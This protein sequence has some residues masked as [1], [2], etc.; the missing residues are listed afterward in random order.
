MLP[1]AAGLGRGYS[2]RM[3]R[4]LLLVSALV[5]AAAWAAVAGTLTIVRWPPTAAAI[6]EVRDAGMRGCAGRYS[7]PAA[8]GR[9]EVLF[10]T[11]YVMERNIAVFTRALVALGPL[12]AVGVWAAVGRR[13]QTR[14]RSA[15][16]GAARP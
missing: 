15:G 10:E 11:Q 6:V 2:R 13:R 8:R 7:E 9:C 1:I 16:R 14:S 4:A 3:R 12:A 5:A